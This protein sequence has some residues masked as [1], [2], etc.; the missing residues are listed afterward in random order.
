MK[1]TGTVLLLLALSS[2]AAF[3]QSPATTP[4]RAAA[5]QAADKGAPVRPAALQTAA[6]PAVERRD[7]VVHPADVED[8]HNGVVFYDLLRNRTLLP[9]N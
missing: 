7:A 2:T 6:A 4:Q 8:R 9:S 3:A 1:R 5:A